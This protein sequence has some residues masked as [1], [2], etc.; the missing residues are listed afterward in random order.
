MKKQIFF[1]SM[2]FA[3]IL[4][5]GASSQTD[6]KREPA[7]SVSGMVQK[8]LFLS[9]TDL[10]RFGSVSVKV[11]EVLSDKTYNGNFQY[12]GV[13]LRTL[14]ELASIK[15][16]VPEYSKPIDLAIVLKN[17][18]GEKAVLSWGEVFYRNPS[19]AVIALSAD[20]VRAMKSC[21]NCHARGAYEKW[22]SPLGRRVGL[23]K[24][25]L[26]NDFYSDRCIEDITGIEVVDV[27]P[28][29]A[30]ARIKEL[31]ANAFTITGESVKEKMIESLKSYRHTAIQVKHA[32][33]GRGYHGIEKYEGVPLIDILEENKITPSLDSILVFSA[34]DGYRSALSYGEISMTQFG[35]EI[36]I[37]DR[38]EGKS[39][40]KDGKFNLII[41]HDLSS[42]RW[43][44]ALEKI[45]IIKL[46]HDPKL[47][48]IGVGCGDT[49][50]IT[51][52]ALSAI[53]GSDVFVCSRDLQTRFGSYMAGKPVLFDP[54]LNMPYYY[55]KIKS[56][57]TEEDI[58]KATNDLRVKNIELLKKALREGKNIGFLDYGDPTI[59]GS[60][61]YWLLANFAK[62][63]YRVIP[64]ISAF[65]AANAMIAK[66][67]AVNG[68]AVIT[69]PNGIRT[70]EAMVKA[71]AEKGDTLAIFVGL[72]EMKG[73]MPIFNKYYKENTPVIVVYKA[74]YEK[75]GRLIKTD[76]SKVIGIIESDDEKHLGL[77]YIGEALR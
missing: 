55:R 60:W 24:L 58:K 54:L 45:E 18:K 13:P 48:I 72:R 38:K 8:P 43:V 74:G 49:D 64:G 62:G 35:R 36:I 75:E 39:I 53:A 27:L 33:E 28:R 68:S 21:R 12:R 59:F 14:L 19:D 56:K 11:T 77:I 40:E 76:L 29:K 32:G 9:M 61:T 73:L 37:A 69:V 57:L 10:S 23:P 5:T 31:R 7:L 52:E 17:A 4:L 46:R 67:V 20:P 26:T 3:V 15:K 50:L 70:N 47:Y 44:K 25:V 71:V 16:K 65:N 22:E 42:D 34:P 63:E 51:L 6:T 30:S 2:L 1:S 66:N 41:R